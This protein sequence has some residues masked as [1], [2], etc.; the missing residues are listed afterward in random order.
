[1]FTFPVCHFASG[2]AVDVGVLSL[3]SSSV[4]E[5]D[6]VTFSW[7]GDAENAMLCFGDEWIGGVVSFP[8]TMRV[9]TYHT[10]NFTVKFWDGGTEYET[11]P[12]ALTVA[13]SR[14]IDEPFTTALTG[15]WDTEVGTV[16]LASNRMNLTLNGTRNSISKDLADVTRL[17][18][19]FDFD[20]SG[21]TSGNAFLCTIWNG[22]TDLIRVRAIY[23]ASGNIFRLERRAVIQ[24]DTNIEYQIGGSTTSAGI[25]Q[26]TGTVEICY[27]T[28]DRKYAVYING[29]ILEAIKPSVAEPFE[30]VD[31]IEFGNNLATAQGGTAWI[32]NV[33]VKVGDPATQYITHSNQLAMILGFGQSNFAG[34][35][36]GSYSSVTDDIGDHTVFDA[37]EMATYNATRPKIPLSAAPSSTTVQY[38]FVQNIR[39]PFNTVPILFNPAVGSTGFSTDPGWAA[40]GL[41]RLR[42]IG[43]LELMMATFENPIPIVLMFQGFESDN[44]LAGSGYTAA[45][46]SMIAEFRTAASNSK[47]PFIVGGF[48]PAQLTG[49]EDEDTDRIALDSENQAVAAALDFGAYA[50]SVSPDDAEY[51]AGDPD[52]IHFTGA[53]YRTMGARHAAAF[54]GLLPAAA[55]P[56]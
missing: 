37:G 5:G 3:S 13:A 12:V 17:R 56:E 33:V 21:Q 54:I 55:P 28:V 51:Q 50:S 48:S 49:G 14:L 10:G 16:D 35:A 32:D 31:K 52:W 6:E 24:N 39:L 4:T 43:S 27:D 41:Y 29:T 22:A 1:M 36:A 25:V 23:S 20:I 8:H 34:A 9:A 44:S 45:L 47:L 30:A 42:A 2:N 19:K 38:P 53:G 11:A 26:D 18:V 46:N 15:V 7:T 40:D